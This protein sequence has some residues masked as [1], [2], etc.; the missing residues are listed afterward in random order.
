MKAEQG[1]EHE[2]QKDAVAMLR[3]AVAE[4]PDLGDPCFR[5]GVALQELGNLD[6]GLQWLERAASLSPDV[7]LVQYRFADA[8]W[9]AGQSARAIGHYQAALTQMP[10]SLPLVLDL[11]R[12]LHACGL[13]DGAIAMS[14]R[15]IVL[16]PASF[17]ANLQMGRSQLSLERFGE[18]ELSLRRALEIDPFHFDARFAHGLAAFRAGLAHESGNEFRRAIEIS[19]NE[20]AHRNLVFGM[21]FDPS[22]D[23][24]KIATAARSWAE[25]YADPLRDHVRPHPHDRDPERKLRIGYV[26]PNFWDHCQALFMMPLLAAHDHSRHE[27]VCYASVRRPDRI[28]ERLRAHADAWHDVVGHDDLSL[29]ERIRKDGIDVLVDLTMHMANSRLRVFACRPAPVQITWLAYPGTTG[30]SQVDYRITDR[31]IDPPASADVEPSDPFVESSS[32]YSERSIVLPDTFWC[33]DPLTTEAKVSSLPALANEGITFGCL[34]N[35][36]KINAG[37]LRLW[38]KVLG[39]VDRSRLLLRVPGAELR[40]RVL[41][42]LHRDGI[43][44]DRVHFV[45]TRPRADYLA[46]Y[47]RIDV[48]LDTFPYNGHTTSLDALWMGVP[49]V[50]RVGNTVVGR[51]GLCHACN[52]GLPELIAH[53]DEQYVRSAVEL[54]HDWQG[55]AN[56]RAGLR[57]RMQRSPLMDASRFARN[58]EAAFRLAWRQWCRD[59]E[60]S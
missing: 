6:E 34:N 20:S 23:A 43:D 35:F 12:T 42:E 1:R 54:A 59:G 40:R 38:A 52:L 44:A 57:E 10:T 28:T 7:G 3:R 60:A 56:L 26:S 39:A 17:E 16:E 47:G 46:T 5:L 31:F 30:L 8:L 48:C 51:A 18:A 32:I 37:V 24:A 29:A 49:V 25:R 53:D 36:A 45:D 13:F 33:Y 4:R 21:P 22:A 19:P 27:I 11:A 50:T 58:L 55:L 9:V 15:A 14:A 2:S 41:N